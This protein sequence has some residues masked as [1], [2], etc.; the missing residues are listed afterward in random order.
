MNGFESINK[1]EIQEIDGKSPEGDAPK[2]IVSEHWC[3]R[4][5]VVI[6]IDGKK[7]TV[8]VSELRKAIENAVNAHV[9]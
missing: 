1:I 6:E 2:M 9:Y 4:T 8:R 5:L 7:H 3:Y